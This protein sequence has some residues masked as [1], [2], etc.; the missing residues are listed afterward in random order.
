MAHEGADLHAG[1][2]VT[3]WAGVLQLAR[4]GS[5]FYNVAA[6]LEVEVIAAVV[7]GGPA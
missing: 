6:G 2:G 3:G 1:R 4:V 5:G 7:I